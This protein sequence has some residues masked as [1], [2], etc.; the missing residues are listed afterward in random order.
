MKRTALVILALGLGYAAA[1]GV[2]LLDDAD[3]TGVS[4]LPEGWTTGNARVAVDA[5]VT[6]M[7]YNRINLILI[8]FQKTEISD[9]LFLFPLEF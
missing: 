8:N 4:R 2:N 1:G 7:I 5:A 6:Q 9:F 3:F